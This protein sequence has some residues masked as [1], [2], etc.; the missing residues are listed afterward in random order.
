MKDTMEAIRP[1][2]KS[3]QWLDYQDYVNSLIIEGMT[4]AICASMDDLAHQINFD[5]NKEIGV[6][7]FDVKID[8]IDEELNFD[9]PIS[10]P[11]NIE[12]PNDRSI[13]SIIF[14]IAADFIKIGREMV[15]IDTGAGDYICEI[16]DQFAIYGSLSK[17]TKNFKE[18][19]HQCDVYIQQYEEFSF[20]WKENLDESFKAFIESG[21][22]P[23]HMQTKKKK[24]PQDDD[25]EMEDQ[26]EEE[27]DDE[28]FGW[29]SGKILT[30]V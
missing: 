21:A 23:E 17:I 24:R 10:I 14:N 8:L 11:D 26:D 20:L 9:P 25:D 12:D 30:D 22:M 3:Q 1:D 4:T 18:M 15:R 2:K 27:E 16:K 28:S 19:E 7:M 5:H 6:P 13:K 29:F